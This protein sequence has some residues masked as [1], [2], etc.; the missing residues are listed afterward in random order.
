MSLSK[1]QETDQKLTPFSVSPKTEKKQGLWTQLS[2]RL[3]LTLMLIGLTI[4]SMGVIAFTI[5]NS[6][7]S[8]LIEAANQNLIGTAQQISTKIDDYLE[9]NITGLQA[10]SR[11]AIFQ[12]FI[13]DETLSAYE[14]Q[15]IRSALTSLKNKD[16]YIL[17]YSLLSTEG[18]I[19]ADT[20]SFDASKIPTYLGVPKQ[21]Q[22]EFVNRTNMGQTY[23]SPII[24]EEEESVLYLS[25]PLRDIY[26]EATAFL[27]ARYNVAVFQE[28]IENNTGL[29]G[30]GSYGVLYSQIH[31]NY[32]QI[33]HGKDSES[34]FTLIALDYSQRIDDLKT[35]HFLPDF[36]QEELM[37]KDISLLGNLEDAFKE[38][39]FIYE[40]ETIE[41]VAI[42]QLKEKPWFLAFYQPQEKF[43]APVAKQTT[44]A[45]LLAIIVGGIASIIAYLFARNFSAPL[46]HL[47]EV[48]QKIG[49]GDLEVR[50]EV[51]TGDEIGTLATTFNTTTNQLQHT[52]ETLEQQVEERTKNLAQRAVQLHTASE[53]AR[54]VT[55]IRE[56]GQ[57]LTRVTQLISE[58]FGFYHAGVFLLN[59]TGSHAI[60]QAANSEGG[61]RMLARGHVLEVGEIGIVGYTAATGEAR[62]AL[63]VGQDAVFFDNPDLPETRSEIA[64]P[65][66][67]ENQVI[68]VLDVQ[69]RQAGAFDENDIEIIQILADQVAIA[70]ENAR[71]LEQTQKALNEIEIL[72]GERARQSWKQYLATQPNAYQYSAGQV[73]PL[74][75]I[76]E[77]QQA[78]LAQT[79][80]PQEGQ[81]LVVPIEVRGQKIGAI[82]F[83][84]EGD[85]PGWSAKDLEL[86]REA[87]GQ[88]AVVLESTRLYEDTQRRA[89]R[90]QITREITTNIRSAFNVEDAIQR[91]MQELGE[92]L[93]ATEIVARIG[94]EENLL[95]TQGDHDYE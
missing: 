44:L 88:M 41:Q 14:I 28:I 37:V 65:L 24:F 52:L 26:G 43:L 4:L 75:T 19:L 50:A 34:I 8:A 91:A 92:A 12:Y 27:V 78:Q 83:Q 6:T 77:Q 76:E 58:R 10:E 73:R 90:E 20:R 18:E 23:I 82:S 17:S 31:D 30:Q 21:V 70:L 81:R 56:R 7:R 2:V 11:L 68:G 38:P 40:G 60:L 62:I 47:A 80:P 1:P 36:P 74:S 42:V 71:L 53:V 16:P 94:T 48:A 15:E 46:S 93:A 22:R 89:T 67:I 54:D 63:D 5:I 59:E 85:Q 57:L 86:V 79:P 9:A 13:S 25:A 39:Y 3:K 55:T 29:A 69:S 35:N 61:Q 95:S 72:Y 66:T 84:R 49:Q 87:T 64:L 45:I 33:A 51:R 32:L